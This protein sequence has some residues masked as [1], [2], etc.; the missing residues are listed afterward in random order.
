MW[1]M[2]IPLTICSTLIDG[3]PASTVPVFPISMSLRPRTTAVAA[4]AFFLWRATVSAFVQ[5]A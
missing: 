5:L 4:A 1:L 2:R 3:I